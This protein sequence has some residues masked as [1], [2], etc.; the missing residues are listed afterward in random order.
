MRVRRY[1]GI[2][3]E[4]QRG[5]EACWIISALDFYYVV[6]IRLMRTAEMS[7]GQQTLHFRT[8]QRISEALQDFALVL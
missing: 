5:D 1:L 3:I 7:C 2:R 4:S 6:A 8:I